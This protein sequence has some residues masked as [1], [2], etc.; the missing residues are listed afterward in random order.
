MVLVICFRRKK[1]KKLKLSN[2][3]DKSRKELNG[4]ALHFCEC[5]KNEVENVTSL[6][7]VTTNYSVRQASSFQMF[8]QYRNPSN[9]NE[10]H[11]ATY[12]EVSSQSTEEDKGFYKVQIYILSRKLVFEIYLAKESSRLTLHLFLPLPILERANKSYGCL[13]R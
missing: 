10:T 1:S 11:F 8:K 3:Q 2:N 6:Q 12:V 7:N 4:N 13:V 5:K 9:T